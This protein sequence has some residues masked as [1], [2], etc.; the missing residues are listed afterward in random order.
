MS[1]ES[2]KGRC[3]LQRPFFSYQIIVNESQRIDAVRCKHPDRSFAAAQIVN[4][5]LS[6]LQT[7]QGRL[8][9]TASIFALSATF[10]DIPGTFADKSGMFADTSGTFADKSGMFADKSGTFADKSGT[11]ADKSGMFADKSG[12]FADIPATATDTHITLYFYSS[13]YSLNKFLDYGKQRLY[14]RCRRQIL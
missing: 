5:Q 12:T 3:V 8:D 13:N 4:C 9:L 10:A 11:F 2:K 7:C 6:I 14:A 1:S